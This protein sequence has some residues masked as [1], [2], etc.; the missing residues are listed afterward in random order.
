MKN[1]EE[2]FLEEF[3]K[4]ELQPA[5]SQKR[6][7]HRHPNPVVEERYQL[8]LA[9]YLIN[10]QSGGKYGLFQPDFIWKIFGGYLRNPKLGRTDADMKGAVREW[11]ADPVAAEIKFG[12]ISD[13]D[14]STVTDMS[15]M[16]CGDEDYED[17][18]VPGAECFDE[19]IS[20]W[21]TSSVTSMEGMFN[22]ARSFNADISNW[23]TSSVT[24]MEMTFCDAIAFNADIGK[25]NTS[26]V[27]CTECMFE[28]ATAFNADI[29]RW[30]TSQVTNA[31][32]MFRRATAFNADI[33]RWDMRNS[34]H[35]LF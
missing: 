21:N 17:F 4:I 15:W 19:D 35:S 24:T 25:W 34:S 6:S 8:V 9:S 32:A 28:G 5:T 3:G 26:S 33:S 16:F 18:Y 1:E 12:P 23:N 20:R 27:T 30:N 14:T 29:S 31:F 22:V 10:K 2:E 7:I 11:C 13:W